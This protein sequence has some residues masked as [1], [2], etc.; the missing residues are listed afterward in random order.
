MAAEP[1]VLIASPL[2]KIETSFQS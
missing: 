2:Q 1:Q